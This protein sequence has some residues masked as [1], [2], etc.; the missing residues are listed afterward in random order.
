MMMESGQLM[1]ST[2]ADGITQ[3]DSNCD[4][5]PKMGAGMNV[6]TLADIFEYEE[7]KKLIDPILVKGTVSVLGAYTGIG[8]SIIALSISRSVATGEPLWGIYPV[9][10]TGPVLIVDEETP[11][12]FLRE[13]TEKMGFVKG[14][15]VYFLHFQNVKVDEDKC[16]NALMEKIKE[17]QPVLVVID[18]LIRV[19]RQREDDASSMSKVVDRLRR[20]ANSGTTVLVIHHHRKGEGPLS[21][22]LRGSSDIPGGVDIEYALVPKDG[23]LLFTTVKTRTK[24]LPPI[25]LI[26]EAS[27]EKIE[28][29]HVENEMAKKEGILAEVLGILSEKDET[30]VEEIHEALKQKR[31]DIGINRLRNILHETSLSGALSEHI[32]ARGKKIYG[33]NPDSQFHNLVYP[34]ETVKVESEEPISLTDNPSILCDGEVVGGGELANL[35]ASE[36]EVSP[37]E[38]NSKA[39]Q[40]GEDG[41]PEEK[42]RI[43]FKAKDLKKSVS[44]CVKYTNPRGFLSDYNYLCFSGNSIMATDGTVGIIHATPINFGEDKILV[45]ADI[46]YKAILSLK[47]QEIEMTIGKGVSIKS[48]G[49]KTKFQEINASDYPPDGICFDIPVE[50]IKGAPKDFMASIKQVRFSVG[51]D[52]NKPALMGIYFD[53]QYFY[54]TDNYR[55]TRLK[56]LETTEDAFLIPNALLK[57]V[58]SEGEPSGFCIYQGAIWFFYKDL[59]VFGKLLEGEFPNCKTYFEKYDGMVR[60]EELRLVKFDRLALKMAL[61]NLSPLRPEAPHRIDVVIRPGVLLL[62]AAGEGGEAI[63][64]VDCETNGSGIFSVNLNCFEDAINATECF[65]FPDDEKSPVY[66]LSQWGLETLLLPLEIGDVE[67]GGVLERTR[68]L[69]EEKG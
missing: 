38:G 23:H 65:Y 31:V 26:I 2:V 52:K 57:K 50:S 30:G 60:N 7:P 40:R 56:S 11:N 45:P 15:P 17:I 27:D 37:T 41:R 51:T 22:K 19:H 66:F 24:P 55:V 62:L 28:V 16:F 35:S 18:S 63:E 5:N 8:K 6:I 49:F 46:L 48:G 10:K 47:D 20:I 44:R 34:C 12:G 67:L 43:V 53:G 59:I 32:G 1:E 69:L 9:V 61:N 33:I 54:S 29:L 3:R 4:S 14:L 13:R 39:L 64:K 21:Q 25:Q 68:K 58:A 36:M 42:L